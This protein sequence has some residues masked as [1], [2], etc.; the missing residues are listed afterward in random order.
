MQHIFLG[1]DV[2]WRKQ[3]APLE[4][5]YARKDRFEKNVLDNAITKNPYYN[6]PEYIEIEEKFGIKS[7]F[8][9]RTIY[10]NGNYEDYEDDIRSL[11]KGGWEIGLH[12]DPSSVN[13]EKKILKEKTELEKL[14]KKEIKGNRVH[15][16]GFNNELPKKLKNLGFLYDS[17]T[18]NTKDKVDAYEMGHYEIDDIIEFPITLMDAYMFTY[19]KITEEQI[20]PLFKQTLDYGRK[21][22]SEFNVI[23]VIWHDNV[24]QM[25][26][27]R[28][29][30]KILEYL[31]SQKDVT[32]NRGIDLVK[33]ICNEKIS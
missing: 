24:L 25:K 31:S 12:S 28:M 2:D 30:N 26:G 1:H 13:D 19:M 18:R 9:F 23:T 21:L 5:I 4:H 10:E 11:I 7:T 27:G 6:I 14:T 29:Y 8:F 17:S 3:G 22:N 20:V 33:M 32:I 16:L 15:Y